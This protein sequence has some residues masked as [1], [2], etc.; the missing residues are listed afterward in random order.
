MKNFDKKQS[1][2]ESIKLALI[3]AT[4][5]VVL[6]ATPAMCAAVSFTPQTATNGGDVVGRIPIA[7]F[8]ALELPRGRAYFKTNV[9]EVTAIPEYQFDRQIV[10][11]GP[12]LK[13][14]SSSDGKVASINGIAY[15]QD[16]DWLKYVDENSPDNIIT[17][18]KTYSGQITALKSGYLEVT[19]QGGTPQKVAVADIVQVVS[20]RAYTFSM[21]VTAFS[22]TTKPGEAISGESSSVT[23]KPSSKVI[24]LAAVKHEPLMKGDGDVSNTKLIALWAS[25][26]AVE[27]AQFIPLAILEGPIRRELVQQYH[28]RINQYFAQANASTI[29]GTQFPLN[30]T[31][32]PSANPYTSM[33]PFN[34]SNYPLGLGF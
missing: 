11:S 31:T 15:F 2:K 24:T 22:A 28:G 14:W 12:I 27:A 17:A 29:Y 5:S 18:A 16:G 25:L 10:L 7:K 33:G 26:T 9:L 19:P 4:S 23:I 1:L 32:A 8:G 20:P 6:L 3:A 30:S 21:P 13:C 34:A